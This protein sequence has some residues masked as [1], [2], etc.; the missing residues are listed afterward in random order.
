MQIGETVIGG[1]LSRYG[2][3]WAIRFAA[4]LGSLT[5]DV[6]TFCESDPPADPGF[7]ATDAGDLIGLSDVVAQAAAA[8]KLGQLVQRFAWFELCQCDSGSATVPSAPAAPTDLPQVDPPSL[9]RP[10][11]TACATQSSDPGITYCG[12]NNPGLMNPLATNGLN[13]TAVRVTITEHNTS[14]SGFL[15]S[16][17]MNWFNATALIRADT[18]TVA[19]G[20]GTTVH[21]FPAPPSGAISG[22][23]SVVGTG[24]AGVDCAQFATTMEYF[25]NGDQPGGVTTECC[26]PDPIVAARL[27]QILEYVTLLQRQIAPFASIDGTAHTGLSGAG[28][29][30]LTETLLGVRVSATTIP[31]NYGVSF[32]DPNEHFD[33]GF[34]S[35]GDGD[36]WWG[37]RPIDK[38]TI[39]WTPRWAGM[40]T[41]IGYTLRPGVVATITE[42]RREP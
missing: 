36:E 1:I 2:V 24:A 31:S 14:G 10:A 8:V 41:R 35:I 3:T 15:G 7:T 39:L 12:A 11:T 25:C 27:N 4:F 37:S 21:I 18:S 26:P 17:K 9:P 32:G 13:V 6:N 38:A 29:F 34:V 5:F 19:L 30:D 22:Q 16:A 20:P 42:L 28:H 40:A 33:L 23:P